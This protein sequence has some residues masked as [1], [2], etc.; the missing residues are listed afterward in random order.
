[1]FEV[2]NGYE[3]I[4]QSRE[5]GSSRGQ[6]EILNNQVRLFWENTVSAKELEWEWLLTCQIF[7]PDVRRRWIQR[8]TGEIMPDNFKGNPGSK[9]IWAKIGSEII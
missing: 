9:A 3:K 2:D 1:M 6:A 5:I 4:K 7:M 8:P